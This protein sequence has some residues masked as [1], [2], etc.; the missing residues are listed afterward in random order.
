MSF[1]VQIV[2][3]WNWNGREGR[4]WFYR[5][6]VQIVPLWN[7]NCSRFIAQCLRQPF[8]LYLYGIEIFVILQNLD[9]LTAVQIVP[10][11]NWNTPMLTSCTAPKL[12]SNCTFMELK[13]DN[14]HLL[15]LFYCS[16]CT[17]MELK[18]WSKSTA[19]ARGWVL[20]VPLWNWNRQEGKEEDNGEGSNCTFMELKSEYDW[21]HAINPRVLIVPLWNWNP[22]KAVGSFFV[23]CSNCTFME[24]K[25]HR[26]TRFLVR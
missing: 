26:G 20:I 9:G 2:P 21:V 17:F 4:A 24:L 13:W 25:W 23:G 10:L 12:C 3:L 22:L 8:K 6:R 15:F 1:S 7:W 14:G 5:R 18:C 11:W 16:N 19:S